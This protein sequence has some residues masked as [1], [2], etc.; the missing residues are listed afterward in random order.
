MQTQAVVR[1]IV[2]WLKNYAESARAKGFVV[3]VSG[4]IDSAVVSTLAAETG[5]NVLLIEMPIRQKAE[6]VNRA[7]EHMENLQQRY[8]NVTAMSVDLTPTFNT[9]AET[10][11]V[12]ES[13]FP[14]KQLALANA[15]S[16]L[17]M[18]TLYYYGQL[19][20]LL[21]T[22]TGNKIEDFGVGFFT[23]YGDGGVDI[24]PIA[25]LT[26][27]Q[28]YELAKELNVIQSIQQAVPTDGLWD[29]ERTDEEQMG[30]SYPELEWAMSVYD[31]HQPEDFSGRE[32]E[33]LEIYTRLHKAMQHKINPI[34]VCNI[35]PK[36]MK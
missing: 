9:F 11:E 4:G 14:N 19:H 18:V 20:G 17:R 2:D 3:G 28:V 21:V 33:V 5:L 35:P 30:A 27:T 34:P 36:L 13:A 31:T 1:H 7:R 24:S 22:G 32:R 26:K 8:T 6:Q 15:R 10:V 23:K 25:D 12:D 29:T 16:R